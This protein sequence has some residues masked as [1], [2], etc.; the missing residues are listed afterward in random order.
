MKII[1]RVSKRESGIK[2]RKESANLW[3]SQTWGLSLYE[4]DSEYEGQDVVGNYPGPDYS[5]WHCVFRHLSFLYSGLKFYEIV[6]LEQP[7]K[8]NY[9]FLWK[10]LLSTWDNPVNHAIP[11]GSDFR[12]DSIRSLESRH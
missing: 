2:G 6:I 9:S 3:D 1:S 11:L 10:G 12:L 5:R 7:P 8:R 4:S